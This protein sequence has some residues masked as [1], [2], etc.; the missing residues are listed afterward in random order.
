MLLRAFEGLLAMGIVEAR[1]GTGKGS[2]GHKAGTTPR[3]NCRERCFE[4]M[5]R[6]PALTMAPVTAHLNNAGCIAKHI[7]RARA[8]SSALSPCD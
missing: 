2:G 8:L 7:L 5:R 6:H 3:D 1:A 4:C